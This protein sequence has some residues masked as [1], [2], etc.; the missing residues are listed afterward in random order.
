MYK[1]LPGSREQVRKKVN[2][3]LGMHLLCILSFIPIF[4]CGSLLPSFLWDIDVSLTY[5]LKF[6]GS[7][8]SILKTHRSNF[9]AFHCCP[10]GRIG[11]WDKECTSLLFL[12]PPAGKNP[13]PFIVQAKTF[14]V[15]ERITFS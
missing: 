4:H 3:F 15:N 13:S 14:C 9:L 12:L 5:N 11:S 8:L 7:G 2:V 6:G 1:I 10:F